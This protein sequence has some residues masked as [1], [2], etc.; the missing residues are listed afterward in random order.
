M[1]RWRQISHD[2]KRCAYVPARAGDPGLQIL[3]RQDGPPLRGGYHRRGGTQRLRKVQ[4]LRRHLLGHG[5]AVRQEP[6]GQ[7]DGGRD[8][9]RHGEAGPR[10]LRPGDAGAGQHGAHLPRHRRQRGH[11]HPPLLPQRRE[12]ILYQQAV[13]ASQGRQRAVHGHGPGPGGLRH[14]RPGPHRRDPLHPQRRPPGDL[15]GGGG[16]QQVPPPEGGDRAPPGADGGEPG[17]DQR[18]HRRAGAPGGAP[19][20]AGGAGEAV[21]DPPGRAA[22]AGDLR[23][24]GQ[25]GGDSGGNHQAPGGLRRRP[26]GERPGQRGAGAA[27]Q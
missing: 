20:G 16:H 3:P 17:A 7:E 6:P 26:G 12:R 15:R 14:H 24:A 27:L 10:G 11:G 13:R 4:H 21:P 1:P 23:V 8:L 22:A 5:G 19:A 2:K 9:R 18:P 25:A